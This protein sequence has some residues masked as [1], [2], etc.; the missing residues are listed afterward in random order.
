MLKN[1]KN[2]M[3]YGMLHNKK[4]HLIS[5]ILLVISLSACTHESTTPKQVMVNSKVNWVNNPVDF[6][7][8]FIGTEGVYDHRQAA[9]VVPGAVLPYGMFNFGPEHAYTQDL[10]DES[11][12][13]AKQTLKDKV[14]IPVSPGGYNYGASRIKGFSFTRLS[15]TGCLGASGDIPVLPFTKNIT[16]SPD[17]DLLDAYYSAGFSHENETAIPGYYQVKMDNGSDEKIVHVVLQNHK[18]KIWKL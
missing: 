10:L 9:N 12:S 8:P 11:V 6:V 2:N 17:T 7:N 14:R 4:T 1:I 16:H 5:S 15:G 18:Y 3:R 13:I